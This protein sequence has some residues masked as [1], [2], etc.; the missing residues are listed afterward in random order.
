MSYFGTTDY[1]LEVSRGNVPGAAAAFVI[2]RNNNVGIA[3]SETVWDYGGNYPYLTANTQLYISSSDALDTDVDVVVTGLT[4]DGAEV[5]RTVN[6]NGFTQTAISGLMYRVLSAFIP[7]TSNNG[8]LGDLYLAEADA[9]VNGV[10]LTASNVKGLIPLSRSS[11]G[12]LI[13]Q[14]TD[15]ASDNFTHLGVYTVPAGK[16]AYL[17]DGY[18]FAGKN[19]DVTVSGRVRLQGGQWFNRSPSELYQSAA[20]QMFST[21][22]PLP[23]NTDLEYR[24]IAGNVNTTVNFQLQLLL[25][26]NV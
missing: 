11:A 15:Y 26:D 5:S 1:M 12:T 23:E 2:G 19:T 14:G 7:P 6:T 16:T 24:A 20:N 9:T 18:F 4:I 8:P 25:L 10:P 3:D 17:I 21:R 22:L 13:D